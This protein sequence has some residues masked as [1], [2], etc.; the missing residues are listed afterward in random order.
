M[1][2]NNIASSTLLKRMTAIAVAASLTVPS[3]SNSLTAGPIAGSTDFG[4]FGVA[5]LRGLGAGNITVAGVSGTVTRAILVWHGVAGTTTA[6]AR[7][8]TVNGTAFAGTNIGLSDNNCWG[9]ASSQAF[10]ADVTS[11]VTGNG[12]YALSSMLTTGTFD[13][14]GASLLVFYN[15][16]NATNNRDIAVF[17]G[18]DSN[19]NN[20]FDPAGWSAS[21]SGIN[22]SSGPATLNLIVSDGQTFPE[23]GTATINGSPFAIP[24]YAGATLPVT[25]GGTATS[26]GLWDHSSG[27]VASFLVPGPN[28]LNFN[29]S[30][31]GGDCV[32]LIAAV[33]DLPGGTVTPPVVIPTAA[34]VQVPTLSALGLGGLSLSAA[35]WG[36]YG[37]RNRRRDNDADDAVEAVE[38]ADEGRDATK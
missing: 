19:I 4:L 8:A 38:V 2:F 1:R 9:Q 17:W 36:I 14:N 23:G 20:A 7:S 16:G 25:P 13:P 33:F 30:L 18:N 37:L 22:Y 34:A 26:G 29:A 31:P 24:E 10:Q 12:T 21:L 35:L 5:G 11:V 15:D 32:S 28:T 6:L 27:S 3:F